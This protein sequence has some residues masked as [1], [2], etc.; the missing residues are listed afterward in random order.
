[1]KIVKTTFLLSALADDP[2][3]AVTDIETESI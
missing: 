2:T 3:D 1:M